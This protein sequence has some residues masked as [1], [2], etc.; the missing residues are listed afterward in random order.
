MKITFYQTE[1]Y[2]RANSSLININ[3]YL[4]IKTIN[5]SVIGDN[6]S[7]N[8]KLNKYIRNELLLVSIN[9]F[10]IN[11]DLKQ[12]NGLLNK[13]NI[14]TKIQ[15]EKLNI[16]NQ[17]SSEGKFACILKNLDTPCFSLENELNYYYDE[18]I[19]NIK[20]QK[21]IIK[22][23]FLGIDPDFI[24]L[25]LKFVDNVFY[26][27]DL[28]Y[29]N[30]SK[31]FIQ[32]KKSD[33]KRLIKKHIKGRILINAKDLV[34]PKLDIVFQIVEKGLKSLLKERFVCSDFYIWIAKGLVGHT[35]N[36]NIKESILNYSN[37]TFD[38]YF[39]WLYYEYLTK[40]D[41]ELS[42]IGYKAIFGKVKKIITLNVFSDSQKDKNFLNKRNKGFLWKI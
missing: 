13:N 18:K 3:T 17:V 36:M 10:T 11:M 25:F 20:Y 16:Y 12:M 8:P 30:I 23:L 24:G 26:R 2:N 7:E 15:Y 9:N 21:Y 27:M 40:I 35:E 32:N 37:G 1:K 14:K 34:Y 4:Q 22:K 5:I 39:T 31:V 41:N 6:E 33:P 42:D 29:F 28:A 38:Q 19:I